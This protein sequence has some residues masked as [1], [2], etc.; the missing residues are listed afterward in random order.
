MVKRPKNPEVDKLIGER[1]AFLRRR[2]KWTKKELA[3]QI[4][5]HV[6]TMRAIERGQMGIRAS[7]L[8]DVARLFCVSADYFMP[9]HWEYAILDHDRVL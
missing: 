1:I 7:L 2:K 6:N 9:Y 5:I 8:F 4:G 3:W